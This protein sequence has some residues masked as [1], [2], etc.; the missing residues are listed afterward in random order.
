VF[1]VGPSGRT[2]GVLDVAERV[3]GLSATVLIVGESGTGKELLARRIHRMSAQRDG[4]FIAVN[5]AAIPGELVES[6][7]FGH[8]RGAFTGAVRQQMGKFELA[9]G[10]TLFLDEIGDLRMDLQSKLLR[11]VQENEIERVG[12]SKPIRTNFR[13]IVA[14]NVD[15]E[16][17]V[18]EARFREDLY[19]R[20]NVVPIRMPPLRERAED[21]PVL[22][23]AFL[24][25]FRA[26]FRRPIEA[27]TP[28]ALALLKRYDWPGNVRELRN[29]IERLVAVSEGPQI[30][31]GDLPVE[32]QIAPSD[33]SAPESESVL[34]DALNAFERVYLLKMVERNDGNITATARYLGISLSTLKFRLRKLDVYRLASKIRDT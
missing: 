31:E 19:Y 28:G 34:Q 17:A 24:Q 30:S 6:T 23:E 14:T 5:L 9:F 33:G 13:L 15:L 16:R 8:E 3:A 20:I 2:R 4:P 7:L 18:R 1:I 27:I 26:S 21:I 29:L 22:A 32:L 11:A 10:G 12:A 25:H